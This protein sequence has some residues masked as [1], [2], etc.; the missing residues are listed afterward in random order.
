M[1]NANTATLR[2]DPL[3]QSSLS[4]CLPT[5]SYDRGCFTQFLG[6]GLPR[7]FWWQAESSDF[8][9]VLFVVYPRRKLVPKV[10]TPRTAAFPFGIPSNPKMGAPLGIMS[11]KGNLLWGCF[12]APPS[13]PRPASELQGWAQRRESQLVLGPC[14]CDESGCPKSV[15][16][17]FEILE[18][19]ESTTRRTNGLRFNPR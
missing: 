5:S 3:W 17:L 15:Q 14:G 11:L 4:E 9:Q 7:P 1:T 16:S 18:T 12:G 10:G 13:F 6:M 19:N 2:Q 8:Q